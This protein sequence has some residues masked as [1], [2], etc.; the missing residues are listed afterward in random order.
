MA[1]PTVGTGG[2]RTTPAAGAAAATPPGRATVAALGGLVA[3]GPFT[4]DLYLPALPSLA[5]DLH[6]TAPAVQLTLTAQLFGMAAGQLV[7]GPLSDRHGRRRPLLAGIAAYSLATLVCALAPDL[8]VLVAARFV[9]GVAGAAGLVIARA[10]ARDRYEGVAM[11]RFMASLAM[12]SGL[13]PIVAPVLGAQLLHVTDWRGTFAVLAGL[14][15]VLTV[16]AAVALHESLPPERRHRGGLTTTLQAIGGLVRDRRFL[17]YVLTSTFAFGALFAYVSGSSTVLQEVYRVS[18]QT[19][20]LLFA[21][22]SVALMA[23][24]QLNGRV[25]VTRLRPAALM[26]SGLVA[27]AAAGLAITLFTG[28]W[29]LGPAAVC[30]AMCLLMAAMGVVGPNS[31]AQALTTAP[32]AAGSASALL[33]LGTFLCG[34]V[35]APLSSAGGHPSAVLLGAVV[36]GSALLAL[37]AFLTLCRPWRQEGEAAA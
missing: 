7:F 12:I 6:A 23:S 25:L 13:A 28:V 37:V 36:L 8:G 24:T 31:A 18:P 29:D 32:H 17:G 20:S 11:I 33:G 26:L 1:G 3:L 2:E 34:A 16:L 22:N 9:Q 27:A 15:A 14:G 35:V 30:P 5:A 10:V 19:Y 4:T 21:V